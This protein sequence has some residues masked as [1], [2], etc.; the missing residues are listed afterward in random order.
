MLYRRAGLGIPQRHAHQHAR[1]VG[2]HRMA[3]DG[4]FPAIQNDLF[5]LQ[6][7]SRGGF[8]LVQ[9]IQNRLHVLHPLAPEQRRAGSRGWQA[10]GF[11]TRVRGLEDCEAVR[12]PVVCEG[13]VAVQGG[14]VVRGALAVGEEDGGEWA[15]CC[16]WEG[17][18]ELQGHWAGGDGEGDGG[19]GYG[20]GG[21]G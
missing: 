6:E 4:N 16:C 2:A 13:A 11:G 7:V 5:A 12:C 19:Y 20:W 10:E 14:E 15:W 21:G 17:E 18:A 3:R 9:T 8:D 1:R